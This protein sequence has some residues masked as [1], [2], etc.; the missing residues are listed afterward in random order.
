[1][2]ACPILLFG[3]GNLFPPAYT[4]EQSGLPND[5]L[6]WKAGLLHDNPA[7][8]KATQPQV[9]L[10]ETS[11]HTTAKMPRIAYSPSPFSILIPFTPLILLIL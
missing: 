1:M 5:Q 10:D 11:H 9:T 6:N 2:L 8:V 3:Y 7:T 4:I